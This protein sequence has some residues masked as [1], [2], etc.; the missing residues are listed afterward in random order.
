MS[1]CIPAP[2]PPERSEKILKQ[3]NLTE[4]EFRAL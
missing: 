4:E 2:S 1:P 3:A